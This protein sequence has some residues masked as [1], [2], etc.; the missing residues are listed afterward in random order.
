MR[1]MVISQLQL[2]HITRWTFQD[3]ILLPFRPKG[4]SSCHL[5]SSQNY[6]NKSFS[7]VPRQKVPLLPCDA[8]FCCRHFCI[9]THLF[10]KMPQWDVREVHFEFLADCIKLSLKKPNILTATI[11][12]CAALKIGVLAHLPTSTSLLTLYSKAGNFTSSRVFFEDIHNKDV[13]VWNAIIS[14]SLQNNCY[15]TAIEFFKKMVKAQT[16]FDSTTLLLMVSTLLHMKNFDQGKSIHCVSIKYMMLVD[17]SL[18]NAFIDMYA[19]FGDLNSS[20]CLFEE[21]EYKDVVSWNSIMRGS[22]YNGDLEKSLRYFQ[23]MSFSGETADHV[24]LSCVIS[25]CSSLRELAFG[26]C[27]HGQGIKLGYMDSSRVSVANSLISLYSQC[28][29]VEVAETIFGEIAYKD[30]V[31]WNA[32]MEGYASNENIHEV[33][34]LLV[35]MQTTGP[36]QPDIVTLT[37]IL[38]LCAE[39]MLSREGR[40]VHGFAIRRQMLSDHRPLLN[41]L[42]DMY[43]KCNLVAKA[44][45]LF[46]STTERDLVSWNAMI[47][48]YS[49]NKYSEKAQNLFKELICSGRNCTSSTVFSVLSSCNCPNSLYFGKSVHCWQLKA[50]FLHHILLINS[51]MHTYINCGD[52]TA[53]FS[54]LQENSDIADIASWNTIIAGCVRSD[55]FQE[56][57]ET[58][59][60]LMRQ[61]PLFNHDSITLVNVLSAC[62]NMELLNQG[63]TLH[64]IALKSPF[65]SDT[66]VQNSLITMYGRCRDIDSARKVFK[67]HSN[68]NLCTWN[69]MISA[70]SH[71]KESREALELFHCLQFKPNEFTVV[72]ILSACTQI[73]VLRQGKQVHAYMFRSGYQENS[74]IS[75]ALVDFYSNCGRLDN[76]AQVFRHSQKSESAWN[77]IIAAYG[78]HGNGEKAIKLFN[79]MC[80][81]GTKVTK[82]TFV[83]LLSACSHSGLVKQGL[84]Y[85]ECMF[86]KYGI[87]P[88][89]DHQVYVVNMLGRSGKL[90][91]A[92]EFTKGLQCSGVWGM[93]LSVCNYHGEVKLGKKVAERLFEME[94]ENVGYYISLSNMYVAAGSWK[95]AT[96]LRQ[97]ICDQGLRKCAGYSLIDVGLG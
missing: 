4:S 89:A 50:G 91:E 51:L 6:Q 11:V 23:R 56:A 67:F 80:K 55:H 41:G 93:L 29:A 70:L 69:C 20:E 73:G 8:A 2:K 96:E 77:S 28:E 66:R 63:K 33:F 35:E 9:A 94:P 82:S 92:Y 62:A 52:L 30:I 44:E 85:Y 3:L 5:F 27:V 47:S 61:G 39:L 78:N 60:R 87:Q 18:C 57:L 43:S 26:Q 49:L 32:M 12:H 34:D 58:F 84:M 54:I 24:G 90:D 7:I 15:K 22:L 64:S 38:P 42:I 81:S 75:A 53:G 71:N 59:L 14:A 48:G 68:S 74:F 10:D 36:F 97:S 95:D 21:M 72:S 31:S 76:A 40:T 83:S 13:I 16:R 25:V 45:L 19:K 88:E 65:G 79:E 1:T 86:E 46:N 17:I 37:T